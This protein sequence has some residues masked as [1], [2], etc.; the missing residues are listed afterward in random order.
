MSTV[1]I[2][3]HTMKDQSSSCKRAGGD[4]DPSSGSQ[5]P[6]GLRAASRS[7]SGPPFIP[8]QTGPGRDRSERKAAPPTQLEQL[9]H[10][11][12]R[13][14]AWLNRI[15]CPTFVIQAEL[16]QINEE[17]EWAK[18]R[19]VAGKHSGGLVPPSCNHNPRLPPT[20]KPVNLC[21]FA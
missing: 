2:P 12:Y 14:Q 21:N 7:W 11:P 5:G 10:R 19:A 8:L 1:G 6:A 16:T 3:P 9:A 17:W 18:P 13:G 15:P 20:I 4:M